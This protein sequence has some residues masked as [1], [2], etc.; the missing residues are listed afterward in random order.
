VFSHV[1]TARASTRSRF[2]FVQSLNKT[3]KFMASKFR[4]DPAVHQT[5]RGSSNSVS[6][7]LQMKKCEYVHNVDAKPLRLCTLLI[8]AVAACCA[9][10]SATAQQEPVAV[11]SD[12][13][14]PDAPGVE[15]SSAA[16]PDGEVPQT[17]TATISG[18]VLDTNG[19]EVQGAQ[20]K[21]TRSTGID[22]R[23]SQTGN[24][25]EYKFAGLASGTYRVT[26]SGPGMGTVISPEIKLQANE[27]RVAPQIVLAVAAASTDVTVLGD[28]E[29]IAEEQ[30]HIAVQQRVLKVFPNFYSAYDWNAPP[31]GSKQK[32][33]LAFRAVTDPM[34]FAG[35][36][37]VA[38]AEQYYNIFPSYGGGIQGYAKRYGAAYANDFSGRMFSSAVFP[39]I[40]HQDPRYFYRGSGSIRT[41]ALYAISAAVIARG[42]NGHW[43][44]NYSEI[45]GNFAAGALSNLYYPSDSRGATLTIGNALIETAGRAGTNLVR[46]FILRGITSKVPTYDNGKP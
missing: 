41:R 12:S 34:A 17:G 40:F 42:D 23:V 1:H 11:A 24:D 13:A 4:A 7:L 29:E 44:P 30:V 19:S 6:K 45:C 33:K 43:Q 2:K 18:T 8:G 37:G 46:E 25:G 35:A 3:V 27:F 9:P 28:K 20:V 38:G 5:V 16:P 36:A 15:V 14:L 21:L 32:F 26:V 10:L 31:M 39:S 22:M